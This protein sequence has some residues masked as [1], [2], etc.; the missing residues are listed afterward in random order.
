VA[1]TLKSVAKLIRRGEPGRHL[2]SKGLYLTVVSKTSASWQLRYQ[3]NGQSRWMGLGS[4][5]VFSL[6]KA[7][8]RA[9]LHREKL[10]DKLDPIALRNAERSRQAA[11]V[12]TTFK[13][14]AQDY[15]ADHRGSWR[16]VDHGKQ[17]L[18]SLANYVYPI[19]GSLNVADIGMS[20]VLKVL[21]QPVA[22]G[23]FWLTRPVTADRVR[24]R[25][26]LVLNRA[27]A[28]DGT[29][30][31][32]N[33]AAWDKLKHILPVPSKVARVVHYPALPY[34]QLPQFLRDLRQHDGV[35]VK[36]LEFLILTAVRTNE[37]LGAVWNEID[38]DKKL[39]TIPAAR[40]HK[41]N[42]ALEKHEVPLSEPAIE[43]L[44]SLP[45]ED[46]NPFL[47]IGARQQRLSPASM[48]QL[49]RRMGHKDAN[50]KHITVHG[51]R[52][53]FSTWVS[54][55]TNFDEATREYSLA[56]VVGSASARAYNRTTVL[57]K[58]REL[59]NAWGAYYVS[60][61]VTKAAGDNVTPIRQGR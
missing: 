6:P 16:N 3:L 24:S 31:R 27:M 48:T 21:E 43:L 30:K 41:L 34:E 2:D 19:I 60:A 13:Q 45:T 59:M 9:Q 11:T 7:R 56:H 14:A 4:A 29:L 32:D 28:R 54:E 55:R 58:R 39:W 61:P 47:F 25:I 22:G 49:L 5:R 42:K 8:E 38:L 20:Q 1:L 26:E 15:I 18:Y 44:Q 23:K 53:T 57:D 12:V 46:G 37:A 17:W 52:S 33:P 36:A 50:G 51:F 10:A 40:M 35:G